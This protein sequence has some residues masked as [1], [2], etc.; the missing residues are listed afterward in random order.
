MASCC[1]HICMFTCLPPPL[2]ARPAPHH[3]CPQLET[4]RFAETVCQSNFNDSE[5]AFEQCWT[6]STCQTTEGV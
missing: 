6:L 2:P 3:T 5:A 1:F 4:S